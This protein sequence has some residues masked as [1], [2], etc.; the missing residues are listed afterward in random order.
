ML[1]IFLHRRIIL[2]FSAIL[3]GRFQGRGDSPLW[4]SP[5]VSLGREGWRGEVHAS[6]T[7]PL[8][9]PWMKAKPMKICHL[10]SVIVRRIQLD[11]SSKPDNRS[12]WR[13]MTAS[14]LSFRFPLCRRLFCPDNWHQ[15]LETRKGAMNK[16]TGCI[17]FSNNSV[18][19]NTFQFN[20]CS[21]LALLP[22]PQSLQ[23]A[24]KLNAAKFQF[25]KICKESKLWDLSYFSKFS[26]PILSKIYDKSCKFNISKDMA[27]TV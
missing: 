27:M 23:W 7:H 16:H 22:E 8:L 15:R 14:D 13:S 12:R 5:V 4:S 11:N 18:Q 9:R 21:F 25:T 19:K 1:G 3:V 20:F 2:C 6:A 10:Y 24:P 26:T 17:F